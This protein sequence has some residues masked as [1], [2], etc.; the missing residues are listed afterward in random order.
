MIHIINLMSHER[1]SSV[2]TQ[3]GGKFTREDLGLFVCK[4]R[5]IKAGVKVRYPEGDG[6]VADYNGIAITFDPNKG[7]TFYDVE[8][9]YLK[10][11][12]ETPLHVVYNKFKDKIGYIGESASVEIAH[13]MLYK[14][15]IILLY[16]PLFSENIPPHIKKILVRNIDNFIVKRLDLLDEDSLKVFIEDTAKVSMVYDLVQGDRNS[17]THSVNTLLESYRQRS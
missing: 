11:I 13:G 9:D 7:K 14:K 12:Q 4:Q 2:E 3:I 8:T 1:C 15:P 5:L 10:S 17:I 6:I 16:S